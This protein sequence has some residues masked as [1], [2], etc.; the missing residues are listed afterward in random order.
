MS[1]ILKA[2]I[3]FFI[4]GAIFFDSSFSSATFSLSR[5]FQN[6]FAVPFLL[7]KNAVTASN[8][9]EAL[10][11]ANLEN[12][13]LRADVMRLSLG[14]TPYSGKF[15]LAKIYSSYPLNDKSLIVLARGLLDN[16]KVGDIVLASRNIF[17]GQVISV[18]DYWSEV[19][20]IFDIAKNIPVRIGSRGVAALLVGGATPSISMIDK[21]REVAVHDLVYLASRDL[22]YGLVVGEIGNVSET[23]VGAFK[24][25][26]LILPYS[27]SNLDEVLVVLNLVK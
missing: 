15:L 6:S 1:T 4:L 9:A 2:V 10:V 5:K 16:V 26:D 17:L 20:T 13:N 22:P 3:I 12:Q 7:L 11:K 18:G 19:R 24:N 25:A 14:L 8:L 27:L 21:S 23:S